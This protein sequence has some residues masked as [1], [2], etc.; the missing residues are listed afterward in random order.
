[1]ISDLWNC[2]K[3]GRQ[4]RSI[5]FPFFWN[6]AWKEFLGDPTF[7]SSLNVSPRS[8]INFTTETKRCRSDFQYCCHWLTWLAS[9]V[10][11]LHSD[12]FHL[13][14]NVIVAS[15]CS[16]DCSWLLDV[17]PVTDSISN[18][19][20]RTFSIRTHQSTHETINTTLCR[21]KT[22]Q[23]LSTI[24]ALWFWRRIRFVVH[25]RD[26]FLSFLCCRIS[27]FKNNFWFFNQY[28]RVF[29]G[30][31]DDQRPTYLPPVIAL[32]NSSIVFIDDTSWR[33]SAVPLVKLGLLSSLRRS[34]SV[35]TC[36][37]IFCHLAGSAGLH[38]HSKIA[39]WMFLD[40]AATSSSLIFACF[41]L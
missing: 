41:V 22:K 7:S 23:L 15:L 14:L 16:I 3:T 11:I 35:T 36:Y 9:S 18:K 25:F 24:S 39:T 37:S 8:A 38:C 17:L 32:D 4:K 2:C 20:I 12:S 10:S 6:F 27:C 5:V 34:T 19:E 29:S 21:R 26:E 13:R 30:I 33:S 31:L 40:V 28:S 1:M